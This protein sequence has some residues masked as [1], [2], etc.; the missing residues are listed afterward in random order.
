MK[1][2]IGRKYYVRRLN[3]NILCGSSSATNEPNFKIVCNCIHELL[4]VFEDP[5]QRILTIARL[6]PCFV[7]IFQDMIPIRI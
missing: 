3:K 5:A 6:N 2:L 4:N 7:T 1:S